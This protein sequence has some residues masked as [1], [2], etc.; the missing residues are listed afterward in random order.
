[1]RRKASELNTTLARITTWWRQRAKAKWI[2]EGD[3]NSNF[4]HSFASACKRGNRI[5]EVQKPNGDRSDDPALIQEEFMKFF[6]LKWEERQIVCD[7]WPN[8]HSEDMIPDQ[9]NE[10]LEAEITL[11]P[12]LGSIFSEE[13][14]AFVSRRSISNHGLIVQE[15]LSKFQ[16]S[17]KK[18]GMMA[19]KI[20]METPWIYVKVVF[21]KDVPCRHI[22][23]FSVRSSSPKPLDR[24]GGGQLGV[25]VINNV[26]RISHLLYADDILIF[27]EASRSNAICIMKLLGDYCD[28]TRQ[29]INGGKSAV[30]FSRSC[31][32]WKKLL[33]AK[34]M[35]Y[36][37]VNSMEYLGLPLV[38]RRLKAEDFDKTIRNAH[39][40]TN[41]WGKKHLSLAGRALLIRTSL[42]SIPMY[43]MTYTSVPRGILHSIEKLGITFLW[44]KDSNSRGMHYV[45]WKEL[46]QPRD[47]GGLGFHGLDNWQGPLHARLAWQVISNPNLLL[48]KVLKA[49]YG[50]EQ[51]NDTQVYRASTTWKVIHDGAKALKEIIRWNIGDGQSIDVL[52]DCWIL[53]RRIDTWPTFVNVNELENVRVNWLLDESARWNEERVT[54]CFGNVMAERVMAIATNGNEGI[55]T[56]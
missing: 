39:Q 54:D 46:C 35:G 49:K 21:D 23:S 24:G 36:R 37:K 2:E 34:L 7:S 32:N 4:F 53:N 25:Q 38:L 27:A 9:V 6:M 41:I 11:K 48:H 8:F 33:I 40:K 22:C 43:L 47:H 50:M 1:M 56:P 45:E 55:D 10:I 14:G 16:F 15:M 26:E 20:D 5:L 51:W 30:L 29:R 52:Q 42:L 19:L 18:S 31:P 17:A 13:Q 3:A 44:Q 12:V 28:W